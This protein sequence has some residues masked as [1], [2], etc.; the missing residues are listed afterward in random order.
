M[1]GGATDRDGGFQTQIIP[2]Q[3][4]Q[5]VAPVAATSPYRFRQETTDLHAVYTIRGKIGSGGMGTVYLALDKRLNRFVAIKRLRA[6]LRDEAA[7][8]RRFM[9]EARAAAA[10]NNV[11]IVHIYSIGEDSEGPYIVMEYVESALPRTDPG[12]PAPPQT[13]EA[14]VSRNGPY[15]LDDGLVFMLKVGH[16]VAS[17]HAAGVIHRDLKSSNVLLDAAGE[18]KIVDFGLARLT[19]QDS[20][21]ALTVTGDKFVSLGYA[22]PEQESDATVTDERADVYGLGA[23]FF[24]ILTGKNPRFFREEDLPTAIRP[25]ICKALAT[26]RDARF[27][28]V[29]SLNAALTTLLAESKAERPTIKTIWRCKWCDTVNPLST[30]FCG[31]CGWDGRVSCPECGEDQQFGTAFC[32]VCGANVREYEHAGIIL[33]KIRTAMESRQYEWAVNYAAQPMAFEPVGPAGRQ[34]LEDIQSHASQARKRHERREQLRAVIHTEVAAEN[35]ERA[36]RFIHEF[37]EL[38]SAQDAYAEELRT[39]PSRMLKRDLLRVRKAFEAGDWDLGDRLLRSMPAGVEPDD[40]DRQRLLRV[41]TRHKQRVTSL[42]SLGWLGLI[43]CVYLILFPV[44]IRLNVPGARW[45]WRPMRVL[46]QTPRAAHGLRQYA[47]M[48]GVN[49]LDAS[50]A[51]GRRDGSIFRRSSPDARSPELA[52]LLGDWEGQNRAVQR[53]L[54]TIEKEWGDSYTAA[55][56]QLREDKREAGDY[57]AWKRVDMELVRFTEQRTLPSETLMQTHPSLTPLQ[58]SFS[59]LRDR[60]RASVFRKQVAATRDTID[61]LDR[62][63]RELMRGGE[64][65]EAERFSKA[66]TAIRTKPDYLHAEARLG[67]YDVRNDQ[68]GVPGFAGL[69]RDPVFAGEMHAARGAF[70]SHRARAG[71]EHAQAVSAWQRDF[72]GALQRLG[73]E[74]QRDGDFLGLQAARLEIGRFELDRTIPEAPETG[75]AQLNHLRDQFRR[76]RSDLDDTLARAIVKAADAYDR[77]LADFATRQ[78]KAG[79]IELAAAAMA[80]RH[81]FKLRQD[82]IE[83]R[84]RL[85][86]HGAGAAN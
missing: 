61:D 66:L 11:H 52:R 81:Q 50:L 30:R 80:E 4:R 40:P 35:Y 3:A 60:Q 69:S 9:Q 39:I 17:A 85:G 78:T 12:G 10:L 53:E 1:D 5:P 23:L 62:R 74:R 82:V 72:L 36:Q 55:L 83:A 2:G 31:E 38:S 32:G 84:S 58:A 20:V 33:R 68:D 47:A 64:M 75:F 13:L 19:R 41:L 70:E 45:V 7:V 34:V 63:L 48:W 43:V 22:A 15:K 8:R 65:E 37:R 44:M 28:T 73:D 86:D 71:D 54:A 18:P 29:A 25:I 16:A 67:E 6:E 14:V 24:F 27:Q 51:D 42:R 79:E 59:A 56:K 49:D 77:A 57:E 46:L 76:Q 26:N 21:T